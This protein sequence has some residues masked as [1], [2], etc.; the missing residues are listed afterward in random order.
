MQFMTEERENC[1]TDWA[2]RMYRCWCRVSLLLIHIASQNSYRKLWN[3]QVLSS[4][5]PN[6]IWQRRKL[7]WVS[8]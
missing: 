8:R 4:W 3:C 1:V 6:N 5:Y 7:Q 2:G